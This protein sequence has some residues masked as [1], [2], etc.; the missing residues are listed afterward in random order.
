MDLE[1]GRFEPFLGQMGFGRGRRFR[2]PPCYTRRPRRGSL[3]GNLAG[4]V[5][6][7]TAAGRARIRPTNPAAAATVGHRILLFT[8]HSR[9]IHTSLPQ[10]FDP[11]NSYPWSFSSDSSPFERYDENKFGLRLDRV[12]R[13]PQQ[14]LGQGKG[15]SVFLVSL[16]FR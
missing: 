6:R 5:S 15:T 10:F 7:P 4:K 16:A 1:L 8:G 11:L 14:L 13:P 9:Q 3:R 12:F 2:P